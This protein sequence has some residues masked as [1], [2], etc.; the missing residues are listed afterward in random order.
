VQIMSP[1]YLGDPVM[2]KIP[3]PS[4]KADAGLTS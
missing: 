4:G 3:V 2:P 1:H